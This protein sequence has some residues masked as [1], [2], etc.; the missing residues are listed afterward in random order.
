MCAVII[1]KD[2]CFY[3]IFYWLVVY[4]AKYIVVIET[5]V[6]GFI[7]IVSFRSVVNKLVEKPNVYAQLPVSKSSCY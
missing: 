4:T 2:L 3:I 5:A 6:A 1:N 7:S